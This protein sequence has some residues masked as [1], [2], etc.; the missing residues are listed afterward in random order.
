MNGGNLRL[1][2]KDQKQMKWMI[3]LVAAAV[4]ASGWLGYSVW[5]HNTG[6]EEAATGW[7]SANEEMRQLLDQ[8]SMDKNTAAP[9]AGSNDTAESSVKANSSM[10]KPS[11][12]QSAPADKPSSTV[13]RPALS[14]N[15]HSTDSTQSNSVNDA[16]TSVPSTTA[17][18]DNT[19]SKRDETGKIHLNKATEAQLTAIPGIGAS[20]AKAIILYRKQIGRFQTMEQLLDVKGIGD[21]LL[22]KMKPYLVIDL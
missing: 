13:N 9:Y 12:K 15:I 10:D 4:A 7:H 2:V 1:H 5:K 21:K 3:A 14:A 17:V 20:K 16:H 22:E 6:I 18:S 8:Q 11:G 19:E